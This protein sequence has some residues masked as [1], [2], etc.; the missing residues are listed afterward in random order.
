MFPG[1]RRQLGYL[2]HLGR[3]IPR[4]S[5]KQLAQG[6]IL[7]RM[8]YLLP[9]WGA[10]GTTNLNRAQSL[11]NATARWVT[12]LKKRTRTTILLEKTGWLSV[13]EQLILSTAVIT[14]KLVNLGKPGRLLLRMQVLD[15]KE[16]QT[17]PNRLQ[18]NK[19]AMRW[20]AART[21]NQ[22]TM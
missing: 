2:K 3:Q 18:T 16:I 7:S 19:E 21:W 4:S 9:L 6:L 10:A 15:N 5:R 1:I 20:R 14:W 17:T 11:M 22:L 8:W 13:R 12:G